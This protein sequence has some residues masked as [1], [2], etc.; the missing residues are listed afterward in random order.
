MQ[1][2]LKI[3]L[4]GILNENIERV[5]T[6]H[7][8]DIS[9]AYKIETVTNAYFL[10][11]N[12][13]SKALNMFE[14]EA[15]GLQLIAN[16]N[17]IKTPKVLAYNRFDNHAFLLMEFIES[18]SPSA[19]D[20]EHLGQ[21][22]A[23]LHQCDSENFGLD[24]DNFIG[25]LPQSNTQHSNWVDFYI[26]ERLH[27]QFKLAHRKSLLASSEIPSVEKMGN[28]LSQLFKNIKPSLLHGDLWSGNYLISEDDTPYL[29]D[30]A[31]YFGHNEVDIAMSKLFGGFGESFYQVYAEIIPFS[32][33]TSA[34]ME[35]YQLYYLLVHLNLFGNSYRNSVK[36]ILKKFF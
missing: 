29:I 6:V 11:T 25:S 20:F 1:T 22:L 18:K 10:K 17:T 21:Q 36:T 2:D 7:G 27:P 3:H 13:V 19:K 34:R 23:Q 26:H 28:S 33:E 9:T 8:G 24:T 14:I 35:I 32:N 5:S 4:S 16:T 15:N 30:P 12:Q 31:V